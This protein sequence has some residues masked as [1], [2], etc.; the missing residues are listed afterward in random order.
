MSQRL[1]RRASKPPEANWPWEGGVTFGDAER[2]VVEAVVEPVLEEVGVPVDVL[3]GIVDVV[4]DPLPVGDGARIAALHWGSLVRVKLPILTSLEEID[5]PVPRPDKSSVEIIRDSLETF[6][7]QLGVAF[8]HSVLRLAPILPPFK[9]VSFAI[10]PR[11]GGVNVWRKTRPKLGD[12]FWKSW[13]YCVFRQLPKQIS[14]ES[15]RGSVLSRKHGVEG[16][17]EAEVQVGLLPSSSTS[18]RTGFRL[19]GRKSGWLFLL[20]SLPIESLDRSHI[21]LVQLHFALVA[22]IEG[23]H[24]S[25]E[26]AKDKM[27]TKEAKMIKTNLVG[28]GEAKTVAKL[29]SGRLKQVCSFQAV[30]RPGLCVVK[31]RIAAIYWKWRVSYTKGGLF[32]F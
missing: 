25:A 19:L 8:V 6:R 18:S 5:F 4:R 15:V 14:F 9:E 26:L 28:V 2:G 31:V 23:S 24:E 1:G 12:G 11:E 10:C 13:S 27:R 21:V 16:G 17:I 7:D 20:P 32:T 22:A 29:M 30:D 3:G